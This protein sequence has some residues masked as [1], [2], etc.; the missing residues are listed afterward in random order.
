LFDP[1]D[2]KKVRAGKARSIEIQKEG[3]EPQI[4][5]IGDIISGEKTEYAA[6]LRGGTQPFAITE[7]IHD[8][9]FKNL[10]RLDSSAIVDAASE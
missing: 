5:D 4:L 6:A 8:K 3:G 10:D 1:A 2:Q 7:A 9:L